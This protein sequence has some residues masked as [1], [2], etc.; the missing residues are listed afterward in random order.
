MWMNFFV[1]LIISVFAMLGFSGFRYIDK[2]KTQVEVRVFLSDSSDVEYLQSEIVKDVGV[3]NVEF[4]SKEY[5]LQEF[6][7][8]FK[9]SNLPTINP[10]PASFIVELNPRYKTTEYLRSFSKRIETLNGVDKVVYGE[11]YIQT[12][13][14]VSQYFKW[15]SYGVSGLLFLLFLFTIIMSINHKVLVARDET[16]FLSLFGISKLKLKIRLGSKFA[17]E[18]LVLSGIAVA[19]VY[20]VSKFILLKSDVTLPIDFIFK[21][22]GGCG[23][24]TFFILLTKKI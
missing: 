8:E 3:E 21:F 16:S 10:L 19:V 24:L 11:E 14:T 6:K 4:L 9:A 22:V 5:A 23:I 13:C 17:I 20:S 2:A 12:L 15:L 7:K 18:N 1:F